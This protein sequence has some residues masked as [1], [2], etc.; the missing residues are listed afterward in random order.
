M[1]NGYTVMQ[2]LPVKPEP[3]EGWLTVKEWRQ[4][5]MALYWLSVFVVKTAIGF[6]MV[7]SDSSLVA[8]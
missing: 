3:V 5:D 1:L 4:V 2:P 8:L 6:E 7:V